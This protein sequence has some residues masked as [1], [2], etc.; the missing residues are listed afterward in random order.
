MMPTV[1]FEEEFSDKFVS[2]ATGT[3]STAGGILTKIY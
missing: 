3:V 1:G 2:P